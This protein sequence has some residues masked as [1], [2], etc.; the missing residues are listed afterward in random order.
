MTRPKNIPSKVIRISGTTVSEE[1]HQSLI[2]VC[3]ILNLN[4]SNGF[5]IQKLITMIP[6]MIIKIFV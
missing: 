3:N 1:I 6:Q 4:T 2:L 5:P